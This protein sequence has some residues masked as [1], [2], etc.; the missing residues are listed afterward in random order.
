M[1]LDVAVEAALADAEA[2][3]WD[4]LARYKFWQ[5]SYHAARWVNYAKLLREAGGPRLENPF[6]SLVHRARER[7]E[8]ASRYSKAEAR[9]SLA[10][11]SRNPESFE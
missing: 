6:R 9:E 7:N 1:T 8:W 4:S 3:A 10:R 2:K 11:A 5:F